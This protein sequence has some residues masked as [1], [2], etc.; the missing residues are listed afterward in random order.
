LFGMRLWY[1]DEDTIVYEESLWRG[2][3]W[4]DNAAAIEYREITFRLVY[5]RIR[6]FAVPVTVAVRVN[7]REFSAPAW[8]VDG[9]HYFDIRD[10]A[11]MLAGTRAEFFITTNRHTRFDGPDGLGRSFTF[12]GEGPWLVHGFPHNPTGSEMSGEGRETQEAIVRRETGHVIGGIHIGRVT[13]RPLGMRAGLTVAYIDGRGHFCLLG[14][15]AM[16]GK[17]VLRDEATGAITIETRVPTISERG[18]AA[19][20]EFLGQDRFRTIFEPRDQSWLD[21]RGAVDPET[22]VELPYTWIY[23]SY[24]LLDFDDGG[25]PGILVRSSANSIDFAGVIESLFVYTNGAYEWVADIRTWFGVSFWGTDQGRIYMIH[26]GH[27]SHERMYVIPLENGATRAR[28]FA[29]SWWSHARLAGETRTM[30]Y[31]E[32]RAMVDAGDWEDARD[33][34]PDLVAFL[35][36][37]DTLFPIEPLELDIFAEIP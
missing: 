30:M 29:S 22:G 26:H 33:D 16:R 37:L 32:F 11:F 6:T 10:I 17:R 20:R 12:V 34:F 36:G 18:L 1:E 9:R 4:D 7:D 19:A 28:H 21:G 2:L 31:D 5:R 23:T 14:F 27:D 25:V 8:E 3:L 13:D 15:A 35:D 24:R